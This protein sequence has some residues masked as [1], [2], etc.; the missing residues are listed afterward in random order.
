[1]EN[2]LKKA[3]VCVTVWEMYREGERKT[4]FRGALQLF[5]TPASWNI[6]PKTGMSQLPHRIYH[7]ILQIR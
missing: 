7:A 2:P 1:M 6:W 4:E 3:L 5:P